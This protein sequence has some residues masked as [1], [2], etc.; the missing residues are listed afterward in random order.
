MFNQFSTC[1]QYNHHESIP[2]ICNCRVGIGIS[3]Y[4]L[5]VPIIIIKLLCYL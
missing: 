3:T 2:E 5:L 4:N 1:P